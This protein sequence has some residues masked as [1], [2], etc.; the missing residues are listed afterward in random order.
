M[1]TIISNFQG[2]TGPVLRY[3]PPLTEGLL[4]WHFI[5]QDAA[6]TIKNHGGADGAI[7]GAP[8][9]SPGHARMIGLAD[10][11][12]TDADEAPSMT[13]IAVSRFPF[14]GV[15]AAANGVIAGNAILNVS[16]FA[17]SYRTLG[18]TVRLE[19]RRAYDNAG[20]PASRIASDFVVPGNQ[21][22]CLGGDFPASGPITVRNLTAGTS[23]ASSPMATPIAGG[24]IRAGSAESQWN[25]YLDEGFLAIYD[26][27]LTAGER[28]SVY[29]SVQQAMAGVGIT[30]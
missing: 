10:Y 27:I 9:Y 28:A 29:A 5:G 22:H 12:Q 14:S 4:A 24:K 16:G 13:V 25:G 17:L 8:V 3:R 19:A 1:T 20:V 21:W 7:V 6:R 11:L 18:G 26:R 30:V 15:D 2:Y 23:M